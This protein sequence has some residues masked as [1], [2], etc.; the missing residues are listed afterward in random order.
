MMST[1]V[2]RSVILLFVNMNILGNQ[3]LLKSLKY[4]EKDATAI[5]KHCHNHGHTADTSCFSLV[6]NAANKYHL[7]LKESLLI[8]KTKPSL[9]VA[10]R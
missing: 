3:Y 4:T 1:L 10:K 6:G 8:L 9:N 2:K 7:K 5:R